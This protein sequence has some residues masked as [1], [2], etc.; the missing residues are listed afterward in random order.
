MI[1]IQ[2]INF[3]KTKPDILHPTSSI[4]L[5]GSLNIAIFEIS[6]YQLRNPPVFHVTVKKRIAIRGKNMNWRNSIHG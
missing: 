4:L 6:H 1:R 5:I 3:V 2:L